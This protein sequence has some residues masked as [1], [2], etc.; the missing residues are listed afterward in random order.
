MPEITS[1]RRGEQIRKVF[2][3]LLA[4]ENGLPAKEV[5]DRVEK[6]LTLTDFEK[7]AFPKTPKVRRFEKLVRFATIAPVKAGWLVK[8]KGRW[9]ITE[10]GKKAF[11]EFPDPEKLDREAGRLYREWRRR[12][13]LEVAEG[14]AEEL[15]TQDAVI[16]L[17]EA[18]EMAWSEVQRHFERMPPYDLQKLVAG[19]LGAMGYHVAWIAPPG[20]DKGIDIIAYDDPLGSRPPRIKVQVRRRVDRENVGGLRAF[21]AV[22]GDEDVGIFVCTGGFTKDAED[23]A[24]TQESRKVTL[25]DLENLF[26]LWV[27]YYKKIEEEFKK[28][29]PLQPVYYLAPPE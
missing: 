19:L 25:L 23:E 16:T 10:A 2:E 20:R 18:E 28:L 26:D 12:E 24:R 21:L 1:K 3:I 14:E 29:L 8:E 4:N 22:L 15:Q 6:S 11:Q 17:E 7:G 9:T 27:Q 13:P 5:L